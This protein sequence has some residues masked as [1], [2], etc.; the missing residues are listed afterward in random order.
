MEKVNV[1]KVQVLIFP[2]DKTKSLVFTVQ[3]FYDEDDETDTEITTHVQDTLDT[4]Y[5]LSDKLY[6]PSTSATTKPE[7]SDNDKD[8]ELERYSSIDPILDSK[9][10]VC[11]VF[12]HY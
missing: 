4:S 5:I 3:G 8:E 11:L 10:N 7:Q 1:I 9:E 6:E 12:Y 2:S